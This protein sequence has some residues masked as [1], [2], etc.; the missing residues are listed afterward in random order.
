MLICNRIFVSFLYLLVCAPVFGQSIQLPSSGISE[1]GISFSTECQVYE[2]ADDTIDIAHLLAEKGINWAPA[3]AF[4]PTDNRN[5]FWVKTAMYN[6]GE[7]ISTIIEFNHISHLTAYLVHGDSVMEEAYGGEYSKVSDRRKVDARKFVQLKIPPGHTALY[8]KIRQRKNFAPILD[9]QIRDAADFYSQMPKKT[10]LVALLFGSFGILF[11]YG[12]ILFM[13][14]GHRPYLWLSLTTLMK[15]VFFSQMI[16]YFTDVFMPNSPKIAWDMLAVLM[17][18]SGIT[19]LLLVRDFLKLNKDHPKFNLILN[20]FMVFLAVQCVV[21]C[22]IKFQHEDYLLANRIGF[23]GFIPQGLFLVY[24]FVRLLPK[25]PRYKRPV[26]IGI[27][28]FAALTLFTSVNFLF[29]L[30]K[31]YGNFTWNE[32]IGTLVFLLLYF[33][34]LG[35]EMQLN[36][37]DKNKALEKVNE[38][39]RNQKAELEKTVKERTHE[40]ESSKKEI[41]LQNQN[42]QQRND[43]IEILLKEIHHRVKNNLQV[44]SSLLDLQSRD[45]TDEGT[46]ATFMEGKNRVKAMALIHQKLYQNEGLATIDFKEYVEMLLSEL[47]SIYPSSGKVKTVIATSGNTEFDID[48]AVP[49]ALIL[50][51]LISNAYK[52]AFEDQKAGELKIDLIEMSSGSHVLT[53]LDNGSGLP[54]QFDFAKAKSLGLRLVRRLAKQLYGTADYQNGEGASFRINFTDTYIRKQA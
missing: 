2:V 14:N 33:Y 49:L 46:L 17:Y 8:F 15:A 48:T 53:V 54:H 50:N 1:Q 10:F 37:K 39:T 6:E 31:S 51:E 42:L 34:T 20:G 11:I 32:V 36:E 40:L 26:I 4:I 3:N 13:G 5:I 38:I 12:M 41:E 29:N 21:I 44:V 35:Q 18:G 47:S 27:M 45:I 9:F 30:E 23:S 28:G 24:M 25:I 43:K 52:Y 19:S 7:P 22:F 16:G